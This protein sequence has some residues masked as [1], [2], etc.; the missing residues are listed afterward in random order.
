MTKEEKIAKIAALKSISV[1]LKRDVDYYN[2]LQLGLK[3]VLNGSYVWPPFERMGA[4]LWSIRNIIFHIIQQ[5][6]GL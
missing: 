4:R 6:C 2:A 1:Q 3:L 5:S